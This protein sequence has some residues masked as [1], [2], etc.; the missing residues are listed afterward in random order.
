MGYLSLVSVALSQKLVPLV[1]VSIL[2][3]KFK[4]LLKAGQVLLRFQ[5]V[6][7]RIL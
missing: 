2:S 3:L 5:T 6:G 1:E 7:I 4:E